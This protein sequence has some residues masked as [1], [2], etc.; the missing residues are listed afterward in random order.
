MEV[1]DAQRFRFRCSCFCARDNAFGSTAGCAV[2]SQHLDEKP[3]IWITVM[4]E[5][6]L[7]I[8][9]LFGFI[10]R[11]GIPLGLTL[12]VGWYL[13]RLDARWREEA[14]QNEAK[15]G[16]RIFIE[17]ADR[18]QSSERCWQYYDCPKDQLKSCPAF[19]QTDTPCW[20]VF[21]LNGSL[22]MKCQKCAYRN[23]AL[24]PVGA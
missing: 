20:E 19:R 10:L 9:L 12:G 7:T 17:S 23:R 24:V 2:W 1:H 14:E 3:A 8:Y 22:N 13:H 11:I 15:R 21:R 5:I 4:D 6:F 18:I 16:Q